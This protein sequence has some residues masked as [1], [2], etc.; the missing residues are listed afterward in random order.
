MGVDIRVHM[1]YRHRKH[2]RWIYY[3]KDFPTYR[4][5]GLFEMLGGLTGNVLI[6][7]RGLPDDATLETQKAY[8]GGG[9]CPS[10]ITAPELRLC[11]DTMYSKYNL[12]YKSM[13][14]YEL[15]Y[16]YMKDSDDED[17]PSRLVF[18]FDQ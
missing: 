2:H 12:E 3:D 6:P 18:W 16:K 11:L 4:C 7:S 17:E 13:T 14:E 1:E 10:W 9:Y 8:R 5:Y 15:I